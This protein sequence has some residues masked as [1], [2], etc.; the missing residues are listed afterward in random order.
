MNWKQACQRWLVA[1]VCGLCGAAMA[2]TVE[3][4]GLLLPSDQGTPTLRTPEPLLSRMD[5]IWEVAS[6]MGQPVPLGEAPVRLL[7]R[8]GSVQVL[9]G[10]NRF[11]G[12]FTHDPQGAF[13]LSSL[14][15]THNECSS[16]SRQAVALNAALVMA[17]QLQL[18]E[19]M[20][21]RS[22][23]TELAR[24]VPSRRQDADA[25]DDFRFSLVDGP[26]QA[27][28]ARVSRTTGKTG[29]A[30]AGAARSTGA[31][32]VVNAKKKR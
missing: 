3:G 5:Q 18:G 27:A 29:K 22:G 15:G 25:K 17:N 16:Q 32:K 26:R 11:A 8:A 1:V 24:L 14:R 4:T 20:V 6:V 13:R 21:L 10:C 28:P 7:M 30:K 19:E 12:R 31:K 9:D 23:D 2:Q